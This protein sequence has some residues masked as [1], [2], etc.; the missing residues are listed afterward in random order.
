MWISRERYNE[1]RSA[2]ADNEVL[3][4]DLDLWQAKYRALEEGTASMLHLADGTP[5]LVI[6]IDELE[7]ANEEGRRAI[8]SVDFLKTELDRYKQ[9]YADEVQKRLDLL[10]Y[11]TEVRINS[12][13]IHTS[14]TDS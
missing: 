11:I 12:D 3:H 1:L 6:R 13:E 10:K 9:M 5:V 2:K 8:E 7:K 14:Q 4:S